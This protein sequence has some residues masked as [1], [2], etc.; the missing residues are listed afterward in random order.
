MC[1]SRADRPRS[2]NVRPCLTNPGDSHV[3]R[4][5]F[6]CDCTRS[7]RAW[8]CRSDR[9]VCR[10]HD[11][12]EA[13]R[14][15]GGTVTV[16]ASRAEGASTVLRAAQ[17]PHAAQAQSRPLRPRQLFGGRCEC[18]HPPCSITRPSRRQSCSAHPCSS[19]S[20]S[21]LQ[22]RALPLRRLRHRAR[23]SSATTRRKSLPMFI[24][25]TN[26]GGRC[27]GLPARRGHEILG[28]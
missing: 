5:R 8:F 20:H 22:Q 7:C 19:Q 11:D 9:S 16:A 12:S 21:V 14:T 15:P 23:R 17:L 2:L 24:R 25:S 26:P 3:A 1:T 18:S 27:F 28:S 13:G 10:Y 4:F 6:A